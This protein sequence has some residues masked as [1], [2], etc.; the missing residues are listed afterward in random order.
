MR[1]L[2]HKVPGFSFGRKIHLVALS[3][4]AIFLTTGL[5]YGQTVGSV[6]GKV[7]DDAG[8]PVIGA[9]VIV[10]GSMNV[11]IT[12]PTGAFSLQNVNLGSDV[13]TVN[14]LGYQPAEVSVGGRSSVEIKLAPDDNRLDDVI[15]V[16]YGSLARKEISSSIV[17]VNSEN[18]NQG[19]VSNP[20]EM[21]QGRVAGL[22]IGGTSPADMSSSPA[23]QIRGAASLTAGNSPLVIVDGVQGGSLQAISSQDIESISVLKDAASTAIYGTRG[24][25]GVIIVTTKK[26]GGADGL[27]VVY[28][29]YYAI[30]VETTTKRYLTADEYR[31]SRR[32]GD[33]GA[34]TDWHA[35]MKNSNLPYNHNQYLSINGSSK[36]GTYGLSVNW[37][38][39]EG[40]GIKGSRN[41]FGGRF[42]V[43]QRMLNN[44]LQISGTLNLRRVNE[45]PNVGGGYYGTNPTNPVYND[46]GTF[47][48]PT[49]PTGAS[50]AY[51]EAMLNTEERARIYL[52]AVAAARLSLI[53]TSQHSLSTTLTYSMN[54]NDSK[55]NT[56]ISSKAADSFWNSYKGR[57]RINYSK[58][59]LD[60]IEWLVNYTMDLGDH[61]LGAV[62]GYNFETSNSESFYA[63]NNDFAF[64]STLW[65]SL[66]TGTWLK[67]GRAEMGSGRSLSKLAGVFGRVNYN[68]KNLLMATAA[69]RYEGS[70]KFGAN[71]KFGMFP[72]V[73]VA[74]EVANMNFMEPY[75]DIVNSL[76]V[77]ASFGVAGRSDIDSYL[78]LATY[79]SEGTYNMDGTWMTGYAPTINPNPDLK[80][81]RSKDTNIGVDFTLW[82]RLTG[83]LDIYDRQSVDLLY[84]YTAPQPPF[85]H[86][87]ITVNVGTIANRGVELMLN[88][89]MFKR[90]SA[91]QWNTGVIWSTGVTRLTKLS[92][93]VFTMAYLEL[94]ARGG[95]GASDYFFRVEEGQ[96]IGQYYG[97]EA[98]GLDDYGS[99]LVLNANDEIVP[100]AEAAPEDRRYLGNGTP[101]HYLSW[102]N[103]FKYKNFDLSFLFSGA[104]GHVIYNEQKAGP[105]MP[106]SADNVLTI[107]YTDNFALKN[108][109][110]KVTSYFLE[111]GDYFK[112]EN[113]T[114]GY[115]FR[116]T[117]RKW[118]DNLRLY[119]TARNI[120]T[121][122][123]YSGNDPA[124]VRKDGL[125]PGRDGGLSA[126][127]MG[128]TFGVTLR[129]K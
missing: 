35:L 5:A 100:I 52:M 126:Q 56:Y 22:T 11:A 20:M 105:G 77:R 71:N 62:A 53:Q 25:N 121:I 50:N 34:S 79:G 76:K 85:I 6:S 110:G 28:D 61:T 109:G 14:M 96:K 120:Y 127:Y 122:T 102:T 41:E 118:V 104:F 26:G 1:N 65:N 21:L 115:N 19:A 59:W 124:L 57:A 54:Y 112:L 103:N 13:L 39:T 81:E 114:L 40:T 101:K 55:Q 74:W 8:E 84:P 30:S 12:D 125:E 43:E 10:K 90:G 117:N 108:S 46:D 75:K 3:L 70:T 82:N 58:N 23:L 60:R 17:Q 66:G 80:W 99:I 68:W 44:R 88:Y 83:S 27:S 37:R 72:S 129:F 93:D 78:S 15:V 63:Q 48:Q 47:Y 38:D 51:A 4:A 16:G 97:Y 45:V 31:R 116:F 91:L 36:S 128:L 106:G 73:S 111:K 18:F 29:S 2:L 92:S 67:D 98:T 24:A 49:S 69:F 33:L 42:N 107:A 123:G 32:G 86:S 113:A 119:L 87:S 94:G 9:T 64:D 95:L 7:I 89:D